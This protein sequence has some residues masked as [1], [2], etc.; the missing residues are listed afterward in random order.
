M[1]TGASLGEASGDACCFLVVVP[2]WGGRYTEWLAG[3][4]IGGLNLGCRVT[5]PSA[6]SPKAPAAGARYACTDNA[7]A[8]MPAMAMATAS[9][10]SLTP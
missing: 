1:L 3:S 7:P 10:R 2:A 4:C 8:S 9:K 6:V 5:G